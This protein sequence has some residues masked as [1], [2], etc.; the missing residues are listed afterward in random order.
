[1]K[2]LVLIALILVVMLIIAGF[3]CQVEECQKC[4]WCKIQ[5]VKTGQIKD[6]NC[7]RDL[8]GGWEWCD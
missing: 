8:P 6:W 7:Y 2:S 3:Q 5:N 4:N 1:M